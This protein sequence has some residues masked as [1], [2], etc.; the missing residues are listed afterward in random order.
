MI[1]IIIVSELFTFAL[2]ILI[3]II[4]RT[5]DS[6]AIISNIVSWIM[7]ALGGFWMPKWLLPQ[8]FRWFSEI[9]ILSILFYAFSDIAIY[10]KPIT[11]YI[12]SIALASISSFIIFIITALIYTRYLPKLLER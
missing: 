1:L 12:V 4:S 3:G 2:G 5:P 7:M 11:Q 6:S 10:E 8:T 9:N